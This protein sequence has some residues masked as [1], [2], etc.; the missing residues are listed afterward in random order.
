MAGSSA[1]LHEEASVLG[2]ATIARHRAIVSLM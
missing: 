1:T 2:A